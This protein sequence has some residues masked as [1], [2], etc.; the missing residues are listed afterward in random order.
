M[1]DNLSQNP[2]LTDTIATGS[3]LVKF[4]YVG[5]VVGKPGLDIMKSQLPGLRKQYKPD[6]VIANG[7]NGDK[8]RGLN[9][10]LIDTYH[11]CGVDVITSGNHI[12]DKFPLRKEMRNL[13]F[14]LRPLNYPQGVSGEGSLVFETR[15]GVKIAI[16][17]LQ[18]R[19]FLPPIDC[20]F[21]TADSEIK[22]L[23]E[24]GIN[25]RFIDF[26]AEAT[27]EKQALGWYLDGRVSAIVGTH[28]HVQTADERILP[29]G[30]GYITD[31]GMTGSHDS[32]IG[33]VTKVSI[34][35]FMLQIP[36]P[37]Q[38]SDENLRL[39]GVYLEVEE[40]SGKCV[41]IKSLN[42]P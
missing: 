14:L 26:H 8:G 7:E 20:P 3:K 2:T 12:W 39:N 22:R 23:D 42:L 6:V 36:Q 17:N 34:K 15:S 19:T 18:G 41:K 40:S 16:L 4:L 30:T 25:I 9:T 33:M 32:V 27:G 5:D 38:L 11:E 13:Q 24:L 21:R 35:R 31:A 10:E 37:F 1:R 28:T 29:R